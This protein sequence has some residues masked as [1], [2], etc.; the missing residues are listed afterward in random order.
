MCFEVELLHAREGPELVA[1]YLIIE[2]T[3]QVWIILLFFYIC[4]ISGS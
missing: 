4:T 1:N 3:I 2:C